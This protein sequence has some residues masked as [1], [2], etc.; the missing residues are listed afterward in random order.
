MKVTGGHS[1]T[2]S[3]TGRGQPRWVF[4]EWMELGLEKMRWGRHTTVMVDS[5][6][7]C[8]VKSF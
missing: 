2:S 1:Y 3:P 5:L 8:F 6:Y 7:L 4:V